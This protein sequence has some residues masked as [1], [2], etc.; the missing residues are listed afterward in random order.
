MARSWAKVNWLF[1]TSNRMKW[2]EEYMHLGRKRATVIKNRA[3]I[4]SRIWMGMRVSTMVP[5]T[6][7]RRSFTTLAS[8]KQWEASKDKSKCKTILNINPTLISVLPRG[9]MCTSQVWICKMTQEEVVPLLINKLWI[10]IRFICPH[11]RASVGCKMGWEI[12]RHQLQQWHNTKTESRLR[13]YSKGAS[14]G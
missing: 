9:A 12:P 11:C 3:A 7:E 13:T 2:P 4:C 10:R 1:T 5:K 14:T 6:M 8:S